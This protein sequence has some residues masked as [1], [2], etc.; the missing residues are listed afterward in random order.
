[1]EPIIR[2][3]EVEL[4]NFK[5]VGKGKITFPTSQNL[6]TENADIIGLYG[7]NGSGKTAMVEAFNVLKR[8]LKG[9]KFP[10]EYNHLIFSGK[11][12]ASLT[13]VFLIE[14]GEE[15]HY[16]EYKISFEQENEKIKLRSEEMRFK[17][18]EKRDSH[19]RLGFI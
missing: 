8:F 12:H 7:Q 18:I 10:N 2:I 14:E 13:F 6:S 4:E 19:E 5:N 3:L 15:K 1:M 9:A 16:L 11:K 17:K